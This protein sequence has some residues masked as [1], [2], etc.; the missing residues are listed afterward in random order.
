LETKVRG[1][2]I[3]N[4][5]DGT[6]S[7]K[8]SEC[9]RYRYTLTRSFAPGIVMP[10]H[11][12]FI[13]LNPSTADHNQNDP[14]V[15]RCERRARAWRFDGLTVTNLFAWRATDP[16]ELLKV[17]DP[18]GPDN[19][20][21][22][23]HEAKMG[24]DLVVCGWGGNSRFTRNRAIHVVSLLLNAAV[25]LTYLRLSQRTGQPC[26]P[27]YLPYSELPKVWWDERV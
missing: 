1:W 17:A 9:E 3:K 5:S 18:V 2:I 15:E 11:V 27:L 20:W 19:D 10:R 4:R 24:A 22:L 8:F 26:H 12:N 25:P 7:A 6:G 16:S 13:M 14:T 23:V 21:N